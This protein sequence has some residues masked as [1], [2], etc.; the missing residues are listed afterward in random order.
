VGFF[1]DLKPPPPPE[2]SEEETPDWISAPDGWIGA[3]LPVQE[4]IGRSEEAAISLA[5][6]VAYP[7]G[8][9]VTLEAFTRAVSWGWAL[10]ERVG[11]WQRG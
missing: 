8:F 4:L 10:D 1:D 5:R 9:E 11:D 2:E 3:V 7:V 6:I